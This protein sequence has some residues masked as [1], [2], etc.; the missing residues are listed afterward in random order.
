MSVRGV[1]G[2]IDVPADEPEAILEATRKLLE[3]IQDANPT[4]QPEDLASVVFTVT[5]DLSSVFPAQAA[6]QLGWTE[7][8]LLCTQEI[9]VPGGLSHIVRV[10][11]HWNTEIPQG[12]IKHVYLG[13]AARLRPDLRSN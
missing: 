4:M 5:S 7:V 8:P 2:A 3:A 6:R 13:R 9:P 11:A 10:L 1:R 12:S